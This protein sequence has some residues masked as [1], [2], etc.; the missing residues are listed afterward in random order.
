M[1]CLL[2]IFCFFFKAYV[3]DCDLIFQSPKVGS[4]FLLAL[5]PLFVITHSTASGEVYQ[6][7]VSVLI[8]IFS[9]HACNVR[10]SKKD[11]S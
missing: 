4:Y 9:C 2:L 3:T 5:K 8:R 7:L 1:L 11:D 10:L 6:F